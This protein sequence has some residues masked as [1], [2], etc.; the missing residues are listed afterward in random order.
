MS[1][2]KNP[3]K[4]QNDTT[5]DS[6]DPIQPTN[7]S[8]I[9]NEIHSPKESTNHS[10]AKS[11][12][13]T[14]NSFKYRFWFWIKTKKC[15][16][17][18]LVLTNI[19]MVIA[20]IVFG[21][22]QSVQT[23]KAFKETFKSNVS[24]ENHIRNDSIFRGRNT[25]IDLRPYV[26][27]SRFDI[28]KIF[29]DSILVNVQ[30]IN[31]GKTPAYNISHIENIIVKMDIDST[32]IKDI[33]N[34]KHVNSGFI[35]AGQRM[36]ITFPIQSYKF[37]NITKYQIFTGKIPVYII[38]HIIYNDIFNEYHFTQT[39]V[40]CYPGINNFEINEKYNDAD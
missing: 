1:H 33:R 15:I 24:N 39:C 7:I 12:D 2:N 26:G 16:Q 19:I 21:W 9:E 11:K 6:K 14:N 35:G 8:N 37:D 31:T 10:N 23:K 27:I 34:H 29:K 40:R 3:K 38:V 22:I 32:I 25:K 20:F 4:H 28:N 5:N 17:I 13:K 18:I 36:I 30:I